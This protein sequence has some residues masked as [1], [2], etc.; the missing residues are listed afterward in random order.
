VHQIGFFFGLKGLYTDTF[1]L[2][3]DSRD[4]R[5]FALTVVPPTIFAAIKPDIFTNAIQVAGTFGVL[6]LFGILP[7]AMSWTDRYTERTNAP[8]PPEDSQLVP[9]GKPVLL[10]TGLLAASVIAHDVLS[11][12]GLLQ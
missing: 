3:S 12:V 7:P 5:P 2:Q 8:L 11:R 6:T 4:L 9:G 1:N 10:A